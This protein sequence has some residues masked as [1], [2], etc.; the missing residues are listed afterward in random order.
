MNNR[1][2]KEGV[3]EEREKESRY[4]NLK[5]KI[6]SRESIV[7]CKKHCRSNR[8]ESFRRHEGKITNCFPPVGSFEKAC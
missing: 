3:D 8:D 7:F 2:S 5:H 1:G 6:L 4:D